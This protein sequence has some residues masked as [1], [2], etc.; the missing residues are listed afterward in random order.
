MP[1]LKSKLSKTVNQENRKWLEKK[2]W[3]HEQ[4]PLLDF[5]EFRGSMDNSIGLKI[6]I[7]NKY[8]GAV[9][10][11]AITALFF[12]PFYL[13]VRSV[14]NNRGFDLTCVYVSFLRMIPL[15]YL[16]IGFISLDMII[17]VKNKCKNYLWSVHKKQI[18]KSVTIFF[19][20]IDSA[21]SLFI[22]LIN[23]IAFFIKGNRN[24]IFLMRIIMDIVFGFWVIGVIAILFSLVVSQIESIGIAVFLLVLST[25]LFSQK[26]IPL[27]S[28]V[29]E[30]VHKYCMIFP[31]GGERT[32]DYALG[33]HLGLKAEILILFWLFITLGAF[34]I[35]VYKRGVICSL[36][37]FF[38]AIVMCSIYT[39][40]RIDKNDEIYSFIKNDCVYYALES[41]YYGNEQSEAINVG[42]DFN[43][44][45]YSMNVSICTGFKN[46]VS[47]K[48]DNPSLNEYVFTLYHRFSVESISDLSGNK[49]DYSVTGDQIRVVGN[50]NL[51]GITICYGGYGAPC[52]ADMENV[53]LPAGFPWYPYPS[54]KS[55][56]TTKEQEGYYISGYVSN[57]HPKTEFTVNIDSVTKVFCNV[58]ENDGVFLGKTESLMIVGGDYKRTSYKGIEFVYPSELEYKYGSG[59]GIKNW[60]EMAVDEIGSSCVKTCFFGS[61]YI[62]MSSLDDTSKFY[63]TDDFMMLNIE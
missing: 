52:M 9:V 30:I 58:P 34:F 50:G 25:A 15:W 45:G 39:S 32:Y 19:I 14:N 31:D 6:L 3:L 26:F 13:I 22:L 42:D 41:D 55:I 28:S 21:L 46:T 38:I 48:V 16:F 56:Y 12:V 63:K 51:Q 40:I 11:F 24:W 35:S 43:I 61:N 7:R 36:I 27:T 62:F 53:F 20:K 2:R 47:M 5:C 23:V 44:T 37:C 10:A 59:D 60:F 57:V 4:S 8:I 29:S 1:R 17:N 49:L 33:A 18:Y 54:S